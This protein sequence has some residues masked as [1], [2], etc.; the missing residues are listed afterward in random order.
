M[1]VPFLDRN[2]TC[3]MSTG[4]KSFDTWPSMSSAMGSCSGVGA[5]RCY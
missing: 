4:A 5:P 2:I 1:D 3:R